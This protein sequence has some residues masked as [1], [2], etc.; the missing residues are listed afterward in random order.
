[1]KHDTAISF[2]RMLAMIMII[3]CHIL[4][5]LNNSWAFWVNIGVQIFF[6]IS[7]FLYGKKPIKNTKEFYIGRFKKIL[8]PYIIVLTI[9]VFIEYLIIGNNYSKLLIIGS[10]LGFGG[11]YGN[12][13]ILSHTWFI[14]YILLCYALT[15]IYQRIF[16]T[17]NFKKNVLSFIALIVFI[18]LLKEFHVISISAAWLNN[19]IIG[20]FYSKCCTK[21][22]NK[23]KFE[24]S[25]L[26]AFII[27]FPLALIYQESI[28][29]SLPS[30][31]N[32]H[33]SMIV[34]YGHVLLGCLLFIL[35]YKLF[36]KYKI[37]DN[38]VLRFSDKYSY[39]IY[40]VH[41]IFIINYFSVL[42]LTPYMVVNILLVL[43]LSIIFG[44]IINYLNN[45]VLKLTD[46]I[47]KRIPLKMIV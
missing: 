7:G 34:Q 32:A 45:L 4:Q 24:I 44:I 29:I 30:I 20:Y 22:A 13:S 6:F 5:A 23:K 43:L 18:Q 40:L 9:S 39:M 31:L 25:L 36:T 12:L 17:R 2:I 21:K 42:H 37:K 27:V 47:K 38:V 15:P 14:S 35:L 3:V 11:F 10:Y 19:Y 8:L 28:N 46:I 41:Q 1:M 33:K 26:I 16:S